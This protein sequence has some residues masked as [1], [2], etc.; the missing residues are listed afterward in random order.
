MSWRLL[1]EAFTNQNPD[2]YRGRGFFF[3]S[4]HNPMPTESLSLVSLLRDRGIPIGQE[5]RA[6]FTGPVTVSSTGRWP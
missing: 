4:S 2:R 3:P 1:S 6:R 5:Y